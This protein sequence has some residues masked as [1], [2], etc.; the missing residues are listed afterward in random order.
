MSLLKEKK[1]TKNPSEMSSSTSQERST[2]EIIG[3][4]RVVQRPS[5]PTKEGDSIKKK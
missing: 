4:R 5:A 3:G 1:E 2:G